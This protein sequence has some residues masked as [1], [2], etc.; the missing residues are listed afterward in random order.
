MFALFFAEL[1]HFKRKYLEQLAF[2][3]IYSFNIS[4]VP[5]YIRPEGTYE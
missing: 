5:Q 2:A 1:W 4:I 3:V